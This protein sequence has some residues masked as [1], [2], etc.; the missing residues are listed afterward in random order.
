MTGT[1]VHVFKEESWGFKFGIL[2]ILAPDDDYEI[3]CVPDKAWVSIPPHP[4]IKKYT[5]TL[6][7]IIFS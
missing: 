5:R 6:F 3:L 4:S 7:Y 1:L 2:T